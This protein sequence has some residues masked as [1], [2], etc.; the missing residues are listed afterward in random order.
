MPPELAEVQAWLLKARN[1]WS[2]ARK[3][4][5]PP[6][7][8]LDLAAFHCQQAVEKVLKAYLVSRSIQFEKIHDLNALLDYCASEDGA[9]ESLRKETAPLTLYAVAY[10]YPGPCVPKR[11]EVNSALHVVAR[12]WHF[13]AD[14]V[15]PATLPPLE[16]ES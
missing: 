11:E 13:V 2:L 3:A 12:V 4:L 5:T 15:P 10:R 7:G 1:D 14:R 16:W 6:P 8:E 9:F